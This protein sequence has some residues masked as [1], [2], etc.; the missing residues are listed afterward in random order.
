MKQT[1]KDI[2]KK[3][4]KPESECITRGDGRVEWVCKHGVGHTIY[5]PNDWGAFAMVPIEE[6]PMVAEQKMTAELEMAWKYHDEFYAYSE[7]FDDN[8]PSELA[9]ALAIKAI[10][11]LIENGKLTPKESGWQ[12]AYPEAELVA[13]WEQVINELESL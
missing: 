8:I 7:Q 9:K 13:F 10:R 11:L 6:E 2:A 3:A 1:I 5:N 12:H 4:G